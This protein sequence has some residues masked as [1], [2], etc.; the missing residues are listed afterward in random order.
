[1]AFLAHINYFKGPNQ[2]EHCPEGQGGRP[3]GG[4]GRL[5]R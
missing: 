2:G 4:R 5:G 1:M 3:G